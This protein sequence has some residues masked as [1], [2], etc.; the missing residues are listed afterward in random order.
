MIAGTVSS[1]FI[2]TTSTILRAFGFRSVQLMMLR[3][4]HRIAQLMQLT[5]AFLMLSYAGYCSFLL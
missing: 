1:S 5:A 2:S 3:P 4:S